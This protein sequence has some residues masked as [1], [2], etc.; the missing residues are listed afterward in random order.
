MYMWR[1]YVPLITR[2]S[3]QDTRCSVLYYEQNY[4]AFKLELIK[5]KK[6]YNNYQKHLKERGFKDLCNVNF[7]SDEINGR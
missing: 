1:M 3:K 6:I 5:K 2:A 4:L 7:T